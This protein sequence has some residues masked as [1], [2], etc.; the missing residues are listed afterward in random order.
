[1][2]ATS[3]AFELDCTYVQLRDGPAAV[4]VPVGSDFWERIGERTELHDG[5]LLMVTHQTG[6]WTH[7]EMHPAGDEVLYLLSGK[8]DVILQ[9]NNSQE[10]VSLSGGK[11]VIVPAGSW[12]TV[13]IY[14]P[15][16]L[17]SITRGA[18]TQVRPLRDKP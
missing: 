6:Q 15:G 7:W 5:R 8:M 4:L 12:H 14:S 11:A 3:T 17:L 9:N 13:K 1:M 16:D 10:I 18:G 2:S